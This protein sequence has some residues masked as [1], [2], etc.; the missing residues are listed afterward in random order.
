M[1]KLKY[2]LIQT[3]FDLIFPTA[4]WYAALYHTDGTILNYSKRDFNAFFI[5][6]MTSY[7]IINMIYLLKGRKKGIYD[8]GRFTVLGIA[9]ALAGILFLPVGVIVSLTIIM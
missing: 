2:F 6:A 1:S 4:A 5:P 8:K 9:I 7:F 3:A